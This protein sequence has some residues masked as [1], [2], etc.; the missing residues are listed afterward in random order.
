MCLLIGRFSTLDVYRY[1]VLLT[2][3]L[4]LTL[5]YVSENVNDLKK[6]VSISFRLVCQ[7]WL[8][9]QYVSENVNDLKN[10][11]QSVLGQFASFWLPPLTVS[12]T[13][14]LRFH[15]DP[16]WPPEAHPA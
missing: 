3:R 13:L 15:G 2:D 1:G 16:A 9:L 12:E 10:K 5:Q 7:F 4:W 8:T 6:Q 11:F 14:P